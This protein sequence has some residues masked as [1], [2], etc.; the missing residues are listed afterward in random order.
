MKKLNEVVRAYVACGNA[1][2]Y[3]YAE[4][5]LMK[6]LPANNPDGK[7]F[8]VPAKKRPAF[9]A[10]LQNAT[11]YGVHSDGDK[12]IILDGE[13]ALPNGH[14]GSSLECMHPFCVAE[15]MPEST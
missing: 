14:S 6:H 8:N 3:F 4:Y 9:L 1:L 12:L 13:S 15:R 7:C 11:K 10:D 2:G 5:I